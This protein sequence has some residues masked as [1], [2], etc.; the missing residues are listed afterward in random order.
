MSHTGSAGDHSTIDDHIA[1]YAAAGHGTAAWCADF[2]WSYADLSDQAGAYAGGLAA[3]GIGPGDVVAVFGNSRPECLALFL[4]CCRLGALYLGLNPKYTLRELRFICEDAKPRVVFAVQDSS[5]TSGQHEALREFV[6]GL[7]PDV[8]IV[9]QDL[10]AASAEPRAFLAA[11]PPVDDRPA[12]HAQQPCAIVYTSG[13]TGSPKGALLSEA[14]CVRSAR[15][16]WQYWYGGD[17]DIR[18]VVQHPINH[19]GWLVCEC[20]S[21][22]VAGAALF[23]RE[24]FDGGA[25]LQLIEDQ[26]LTLWLAFPSMVALAMQSPEWERCDLSSLR[27]LALGTS[28]QLELLHRFRER[29]GCTFSVSYGLTEAHGGAATVTSDDADL[30]EVAASIGRPVPGLDVR[31]VGEDGSEAAS[32]TPGELLISDPTVFLGYL[33]R[34]EAT[35]E[36]TDPDGWLHTG[37]I[38]AWQ[39][40]GTL[41]MVGRKQEMFKSGGYNVYPAEI[42]QVIGGHGSIVHAVVVEAPDPLWQAV[43]VAFV[44]P[45]NPADFNLDQVAE[46]LRS[47]LANYKI[48]KRIVV[49]SELPQLANGKVD[50]VQLRQQAKDLTAAAPDRTTTTPR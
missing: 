25:T 12:R 1:Y 50:R 7:P 5:L 32:G 27:R 4:A 8:M 18:T 48:P 11:G 15:L 31:V 13:S 22:L 40:D 44:V 6:A 30:A 28:P 43:G 9:G 23:F 33:N 35:A 2:E 17:A 49:T 34:P 47:R 14:G 42:E 24:R 39:P 16:S 19:V 29:S 38:V 21:G 3:A 20:L 26:R 37:D 36:V 41:R 10:G 46:Y 45:K